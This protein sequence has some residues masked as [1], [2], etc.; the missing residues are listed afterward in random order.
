ML[1]P[2]PVLTCTFASSLGATD[3]PL[4]NGV[5]SLQISYGVKR[6]PLNTQSCADTYLRASQMLAVDWSNVCTVKVTVLFINPLNPAQTIPVTR[7]MAVML[8]AGANS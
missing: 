1:S 4:V 6:N 5:S 7:V 2:N 8:T 3:V